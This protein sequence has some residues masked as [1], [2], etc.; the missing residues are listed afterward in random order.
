MVIGKGYGHVQEGVRRQGHEK[1]THVLQSLT[2][3]SL[4]L[5]ITTEKEQT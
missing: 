3:F 5:D 4:T 2:A 1:A